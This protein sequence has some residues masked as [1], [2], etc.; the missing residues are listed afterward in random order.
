MAVPFSSIVGKLV[1][2]NVLKFDT[3]ELIMSRTLA[4]ISSFK[5]IPIAPGSAVKMFF[6]AGS[7][8]PFRNVTVVCTRAVKDGL[9]SLPSARSPRTF[10]K[11]A[12]M[13]LKEPEIVSDASR[14][15]VPVTPSSS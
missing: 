9:M 6:T 5:R 7:R 12:F 2:M 3:K 15:V 13:E 10:V 1:V 8:F 14:A 4:G 11:L